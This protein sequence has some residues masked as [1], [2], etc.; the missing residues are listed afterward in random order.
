[1]EQLCAALADAFSNCVMLCF[2]RSEWEEQGWE[3]LHLYTE[4]TQDQQINSGGTIA[5]SV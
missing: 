4:F 2:R 1:M 5:A 3:V